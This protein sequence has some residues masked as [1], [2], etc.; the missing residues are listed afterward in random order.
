MA[1]PL[2]IEYDGALYHITSRGNEKKPIYRKDGD[3]RKFLKILSELPARYQVVIHG[4]VLMEN[5]YHLLI[6]TPKGN[7]TRVMHYLN[8]AYTV[9]FNKKHQRVG[10]LF[11]GRYKGLLIEKERYLLS[12]S[13]YIHLNPVRALIVKRPEE[14]KWS[15]YLDY[16][17][18]SIKE[19]WLTSE[20]ILGQYS[21]REAQ[22][23]NLYKIFI[24][25]GLTAAEDD[26]FNHVKAGPVIGN[27]DF[28]EKIKKKLDLKEHREIPESRRLARDI[29]CKR[30]IEEVAKRLRLSEQEIRS[31]GK[32]GN[33]ARK[34]TFYLLRK[35]TDISNEEIGRYFGVG[36]T[37][38][39]QGASRARKELVANRKY[40]KVVRELDAKLSEE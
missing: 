19:K 13:R 20:W 30:V 37:A 31:V 15:S 16:I 24:E 36:Y 35:L 34:I 2:R 22:A 32:R 33:F 6:E 5:H 18:R 40:R 17:G 26:P 11:Q 4:Y 14:Y 27:E 3:C 12:V 23:K 10:H 25:E 7:I 39:S 38:V 28:I 21:T 8:T 9:Y 29:S 1:R